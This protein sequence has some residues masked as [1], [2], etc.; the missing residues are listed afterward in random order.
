MKILILS[1]STGQGHNAAGL[2]LQ[3]ELRARGV[4]CDLVD[5]MAIVSE[6][7]SRIVSGAYIRTATHLPYV[8]GAIYAIAGK[9]SSARH[10]SVVYWA[11]GLYAKKLERFLNENQYDA[12]VMPHLFPAEA[13]TAIRR[14]LGGTAPSFAV[15]TDYTCIPFWEE[16]EVDRFF[17]PHEDLREEFAGRGIPPEKLVVTGIPVDARF[18]ERTDRRAAREALDLPTEPPMF[19]IMSGS[20]GFGA[21]GRMVKKLLAQCGNG[22]TMPC[23]KVPVSPRALPRV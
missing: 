18:A 23:V 12:I 5:T 21:L 8:F 9:I 13:V 2:A 15:A 6:R 22:E 3:Q 20:M 19:L 11:N 7:A 10:K 1:C 4:E 17:I 14:R 16:T